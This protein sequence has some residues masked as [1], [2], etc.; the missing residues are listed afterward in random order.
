MFV[1]P[2]KK[3][4][5][6][7]RLPDGP[8]GKVQ[9]QVGALS[10]SVAP[11]DLRGRRGS[12]GRRSVR[13]NRSRGKVSAANA[14]RGTAV[15]STSTNTVDV[16]GMTADDALARLWKFIDGAMLR[17]EFGVVVVHGH[18]TGSLK[19]AIRHAVVN[20]SPYALSWSPGDRNQGGDGVTNIVFS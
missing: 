9:V 10:L 5:E 13:S 12:A 20:D 18:G 16:R 8:G 14:S 15:I 19:K 17:G 11:D 1:T 6:V 2:L 3:E 7:S 4:G